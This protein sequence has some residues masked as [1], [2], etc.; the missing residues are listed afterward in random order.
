MTRLQVDCTN[1]NAAWVYEQFP[2]VPLVAWYGTGSPD[3]EWSDASKALW[4]HA[5]HVEIDQG[6]TDS[7]ILTANV[8]DIES[9]AWTLTRALDRTGWNVPRP[10]LYCTRTTYGTLESHGWRGDVWV[11]APGITLSQLEPYP[12]IRVVAIQDTFQ[13]LYD[14]STVYDPYWPFSPPSGEDMIS[15]SVNAGGYQFIPFPAGSIKGLMT[16]IEYQPENDPIP[17]H[18]EIHSV[19][20]GWSTHSLEYNQNTPMNTDMPFTDCDA[21]TI[22]NMSNVDNV[23]FTL[24]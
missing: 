19:A 11:A 20:H 22:R 12:G 9:G 6:G 13:G 4:P 10:T 24:H 16:F 14:T 1:A 8:R 18:V 15:F 2:D 7:P 17:V 21:V 3:I 5:T 23:G